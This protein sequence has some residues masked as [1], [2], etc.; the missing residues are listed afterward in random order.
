MWLSHKDEHSL[1]FQRQNQ[2]L[3]TFT[4]T[5]DHMIRVLGYEITTKDSKFS[6]ICISN[7]YEACAHY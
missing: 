3:K 6:T 2:S 5:F 7:T 1:L 4:R